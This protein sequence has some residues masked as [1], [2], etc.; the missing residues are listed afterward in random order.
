MTTKPASSRW[1]AIFSGIVLLVLSLLAAETWRSTPRT[2]RGEAANLVHNATVFQA[3]KETHFRH[4]SHVD[5]SPQAASDDGLPFQQLESPPFHTPVVLR[6]ALCVDP[7]DLGIDNLAAWN[8]RPVPATVAP[9]VTDRVYIPDVVRDA[10]TRP[11]G[12]NRSITSRRPL[13]KVPLSLPPTVPSQPRTVERSLDAP[14]AEQNL[15]RW[16]YPEDLIGQLQTLVDESAS[17]SWASRTIDL[18][19]QLYGCD[20]RDQRLTSYYLAELQQSVDR[21]VDL[22]D[23]SVDRDGWSTIVRAHYALHRRVEL[24]RRVQEVKTGNVAWVTRAMVDSIPYASIAARI[25]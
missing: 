15:R 11:L 8:T 17:G 4:H 20:D 2:Q 6:E 21:A 10:P 9:A 1:I 19:D 24:W 13:R 22:V 14:S 23:P 16:P 3:E 12:H 7:G 18:I 5:Q 25:G